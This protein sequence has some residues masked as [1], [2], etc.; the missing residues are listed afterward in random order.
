MEIYR[1]E[2]FVSIEDQN[3]IIKFYL[4]N[5]KWETL[6]NEKKFSTQ[7]KNMLYTKEN[8]E[9]LIGIDS[10][11][12][13]L[14]KYNY[15]VAKVLNKE[16]LIE[17]NVFGMPPSL[18]KYSKGYSLPLH[19]DTKYYKWITYASVIYFNDDY[20]GGE[21]SF[22]KLN[23]NIKP[24]ARELIIFSQTENEYYHEIKRIKEGTRYSSATWWGSEK[25]IEDNVIGFNFEW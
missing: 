13:I 22:P 16:K 24:K 2:N 25:G 11:M 21:L 1:F 19:M 23:I 17:H 9:H 10:A 4:D 20:E 14:N 15:E 5:P 8:N 6:K 3:S 12:E 18:Y 7:Q